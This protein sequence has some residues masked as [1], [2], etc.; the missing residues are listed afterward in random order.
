MS[1]IKQPAPPP[2]KFDAPRRSLEVPS[3]SP[4]SSSA[5]LGSAQGLV[6]RTEPTSS[7]PAAAPAAA[8]STGPNQT[9]RLTVGREISLAGEITACD[10]LV[11]EGTV[12]AKLRG[13]RT[14]EIAESGLFRGSVEI[15]SADIA[16]RFEGELTVRGRLQVRATGRI[17]G[18]IR[19]GELEVEAGGRLSGQVE[20][21]AETASETAAKAPGEIAAAAPSAWSPAPASP[22]SP[23]SASATAEASLD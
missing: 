6:R 1:T 19:Y 8:G 15:D 13:G 9:R 23:Y 7:A 12:E 22:T 14:V 20:T 4:T 11:V 18:T 16:G 3:L 10:V 17:S 5:P 2:H 21:T